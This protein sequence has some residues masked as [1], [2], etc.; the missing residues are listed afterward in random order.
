MRGRID[1]SVGGIRPS[2]SPTAQNLIQQ[3]AHGLGLSRVFNL[4]ERSPA[5]VL[6][7]T[8][9]PVVLVDDLRDGAFPP[10]REVWGGDTQV[11]G[12][13]P[14]FH[15]IFGGS[16]EERPLDRLV[17]LEFYLSQN[18]GV[19][20]QWQLFIGTSL[21]IPGFAGATRAAHYADSSN[22]PTPGIAESGYTVFM[23]GDTPGGFATTGLTFQTPTG[24]SL[25]RVRG[26][27]IL[28]RNEVLGVW[29]NVANANMSGIL[30]HAVEWPAA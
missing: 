27:W 7:D 29:A 21:P 17:V 22:S 26:P 12:V 8:V 15:G 23:R 4:K 11:G 9:Q 28:A 2:V 13:N 5:P 19:N 30:W 20:V 24:A 3:F 25:V 10:R 16:A 6:Q 18:F 1:E 14:H